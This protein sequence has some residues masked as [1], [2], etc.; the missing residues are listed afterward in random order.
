M[1]PTLTEQLQAISIGELIK[2]NEERHKLEPNKLWGSL[3]NYH[4]ERYYNLT[5]REYESR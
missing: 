4:R 5:G 2:Q 3:A 1:I